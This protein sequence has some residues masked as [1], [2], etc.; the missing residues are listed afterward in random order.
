MQLPIDIAQYFAAGKPFAIF[1]FP[2]EDDIRVA[3][4]DGMFSINSWNTPSTDNVCVNDAPI[5]LPKIEPWPQSTPYDDYIASTAR[6][7]GE[8]KGRGGKCVRSRVTAKVGTQIDLNK[9]VAELFE[10]FPAAFCHCYY[11]SQTGL[12]AG[13][14]PELLIDIKDGMTKTMALAGTRPYGTSAPWDIKNIEEQSLVVRFICD[15]MRTCGMIPEVSEARTL[16]Y[17]EIEHICTDIEAHTSKIDIN[18]LLDALSPTPAV[19]GYPRD[20]AV[21]EIEKYEDA[22]RRC[23]G[24]YIM[25]SD[26]AGRVRAYVNLRC[27]QLSPG[28]WC[29]YAGGGI[30][31]RSSAPEEW[32]ETEAKSAAWIEILKKHTLS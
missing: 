27:A 10:R 5:G 8:L 29:V 13:A 17:G 20:I 30:T 14:T 31:P 6:L 3:G 16:R 7:I 12:W 11:T 22:P 21:V 1:R 24:G 18:A 2:G 23:Y 4:K 25:V 19:S 32:L 9:A 15:S 28:A 26:C